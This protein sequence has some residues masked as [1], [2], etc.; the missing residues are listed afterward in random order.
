MLYYGLYAYTKTML[1][2]V[3]IRVLYSRQCTL[4][5]S[6]QEEVSF[7]FECD[8]EQAANGMQGADQRKDDYVTVSK[9]RYTKSSSIKSSHVADSSLLY[10][11]STELIS[12]RI[13]FRARV[14][15]G[16]LLLCIG[17]LHIF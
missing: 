4:Q 11:Q 17:T 8:E 10:I 16:E 1:S 12:E 2:Q 15:A 6:S 9:S 7:K 14:D 3:L 13:Q 5:A